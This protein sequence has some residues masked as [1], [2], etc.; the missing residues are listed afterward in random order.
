M[1]M[2]ALH[3]HTQLRLLIRNFLSSDLRVNT[4]MKISYSSPVHSVT[5]P[6]RTN[7]N[8][9]NQI[10]T[11]Q[12]TLLKEGKYFLNVCQNIIGSLYGGGRYQT[13]RTLKVRNTFFLIIADQERSRD[14]LVT[15]LKN[16]PAL[17]RYDVSVP[18]EEIQPF[19]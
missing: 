16:T 1:F 7:T 4:A 2:I 9:R 18:V 15:Q 5:Q 10:I 14:S 3:I 19:D 12:R 8:I 6:V 17:H 11:Q 13:L